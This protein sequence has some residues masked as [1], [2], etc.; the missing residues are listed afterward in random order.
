[1]VLAAPNP[2]QLKDAEETCP[3]QYLLC[4]LLLGV[5]QSRYAKLKDDLSK[6][7]MKGVNNFPKTMVEAMH[8]MT[9][10]KVPPR[11]QHVREDSEG[12]ALI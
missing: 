5:D 8:L 7:M 9:N 12:V 1:M 3:E 10:Y 2:N 4:V 6:D 11:A